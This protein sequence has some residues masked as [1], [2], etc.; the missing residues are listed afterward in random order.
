MTQ[1]LIDA[2]SWREPSRELGHIGRVVSAD[3][4]RVSVSGI[5]LEPV[6][7][8][9]SDDFAAV[10]DSGKAVGRKVLVVLAAGQPVIVCAISEGA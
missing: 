5:A 10:I 2:L 1:P 8:K 4:A 9:W 3:P 7:C 6:S